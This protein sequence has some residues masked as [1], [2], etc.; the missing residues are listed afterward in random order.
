[1]TGQGNRTTRGAEMEHQDEVR[2]SVRLRERLGDSREQRRAFLIARAHRL[3]R[4]AERQALTARLL[5]TRA[6]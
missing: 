3:A 4:Q 1:M 6:R 5:L 2:E